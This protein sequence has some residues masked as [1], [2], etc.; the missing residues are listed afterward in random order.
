LDW[1]MD[2]PF[3]DFPQ[4]TVYHGNGSAVEGNTFVN[5]GWSGWIGL[6]TG[7]SDNQLGVSEIGVAFPDASFGNE[8]RI[9]VPFTN[10]LRDILQYDSTLEEA[11]AR[12]TN[13]HRTCHLILG[14]GDGK[15][16]HFRGVQYGY[17]VATFIDDAHLIPVAPWHPPI[18]NIVY[19]GMDWLCPGYNSVM[20]KQLQQ[21]WGNI[22]EENTIRYITAIAQ[23]GDLHTAIYNLSDKILFVATA[24]SQGESGPDNSYQRTFVRLDMNVLFALPPPSLIANVV[25]M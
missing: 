15:S 25:T 5:V 10:I 16:G 9:G 24:K 22:T 7:M 19:F 11:Q 1:N 8:S 3:R 6:I 2:G 18:S 21:Y 4:L 20:S 12:I 17:Q 14:V 13:A 23:T